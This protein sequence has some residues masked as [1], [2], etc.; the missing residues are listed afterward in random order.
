MYLENKKKST[1]NKNYNKEQRIL[2]F[3][4][5]IYYQIYVLLLEMKSDL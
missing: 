2:L 4:L 5:N 3:F 1:W